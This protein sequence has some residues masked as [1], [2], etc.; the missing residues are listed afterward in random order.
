MEMEE[1]GLSNGLRV[2]FLPD[3]S[4][5]VTVLGL[6]KTGSRYETP[7]Q[8]GLAHFYEHMVFKGTKKFPSKK[9]L[10]LAVDRIG[11]E[12]N[13]ATGQEYTYYYVKTAKRDWIMGLDL[14]SQLLI[15]PR[16]AEEEIGVE[17]GVI[18]EEL[19][20]YYDIPQYRAQI[21]LGKLLFPNHPLG[22]SGIGTE[23]TIGSFI[24]K[25]FLEFKD[26]FY[27]LEKVVLVISGGVKK[28]EN[29]SRIIER[30]FFGSKRVKTKE[31]TPRPFREN[32]RKEKLTK[33]VFKKTDQIHLAMG[34]RGL[35]YYDK[36]RYAQSLLNIILGGG[37]SSRLFQE[38]REKRGLCYSIASSVELFSEVGV[39]EITA[40][41][42]KNRWPEAVEEIKNQLFLL[43]KKKV[44]RGELDKAKRFFEGKLALSLED[45]YRRAHF[46]G[47]QK[48][49]E[50]N[51]KDY[52]RV[53]DVVKKVDV[54]EIL[55]VAKEIFLPE[56]IK[57][58]LV[59]STLAEQKNV[60]K[61]KGR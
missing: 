28:K 24:R 2:L 58:V 1:F 48:L 45:S 61:P 33:K 26:R 59:G 4:P 36:R 56:R 37:M 20:M 47:K 44:G 11:A 38:I 52:R 55:S 16:L 39:F 13:G 32:R 9:A 54:E 31:I 17:R 40:G 43:A 12:Y 14:V 8:E 35:S 10:A 57:Q 30:S 60:K 15:E 50:T 46:Y 21:E 18:L 3:R 42:N 23:E 29:L 53:I 6:V 25:D 27:N 22:S 34:V 5:S 7:K 49:L 19:N 51:I 41:L